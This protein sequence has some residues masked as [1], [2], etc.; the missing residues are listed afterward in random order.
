MS[1]QNLREQI[2]ACRADSDD[3]RAPE[4]GE[5]AAAVQHD[6]Q[7]ARELEKAQ[8]MDRSLRAAIHDVAV[9]AGMLERLLAATASDMPPQPVDAPVELAAPRR[10]VLGRRIMATVAAV[11]AVA[12]VAVS[13][14]AFLAPLPRVISAT[15]LAERAERWWVQSFPASGWT[16]ALATAPFKTHPVDSLVRGKPNAWRAVSTADDSQVI[17]YRL[18]PPGQPQAMLFVVRSSAQYSVAAPPGHTA[19]SASRGMKI[20]A[21]QNAGCLYVLA[22]QEEEG[23]QLENFLLRPR[24]TL[25]GPI[26]MPGC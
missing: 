25:R 3:L 4:M 1:N 15:E 16:T 22:V 13:I 21:W 5:L 11:A 18:S 23:Q 7:I 12:L 24:L 2:D 20:V 19:L 9:P 8:Q 17:A 10:P 14:N 6:P 26:R